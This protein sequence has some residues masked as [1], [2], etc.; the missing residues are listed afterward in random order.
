[1]KMLYA[2]ALLA[3]AAFS[4]AENLPLTAEGAAVAKTYLSRGGQEL[5]T[6][7]PRGKG[8]PEDWPK[9]KG[10]VPQGIP[11]IC[12]LPLACGDPEDWCK[13]QDWYKEAAEE[14]RQKMAQQ[15]AMA[16]QMEK[17]NAEQIH[18][19]QAVAGAQAAADAAKN[20]YWWAQGPMT[21]GIDAGAQAVAGA[22]AAV[23]AAK[24]AYWMAFAEEKATLAEDARKKMAQQKAMEQ[25]E[26]WAE[27][28]RQ[29]MAQQKAMA[30]QTEKAN[31]EQIQ[32]MADETEKMVYLSGMVAYSYIQKAEGALLNQGY[33][34]PHGQNEM[35]EQ[36]KR[37]AGHFLQYDIGHEPGKFTANIWLYDNPAMLIKIESFL[38]KTTT[39]INMREKAMAEQEATCAEATKETAE[40][41]AM[42]DQFR[43]EMAERKATWAEEARQ[44]MAE[45]NKEIIDSLDDSDSYTNAGGPGPNAWAPV[46]P[47]ANA[48][49]VVAPSAPVVGSEPGIVF[50]ERRPV[51]GGS[52]IAEPSAKAAST[53]GAGSLIVGTLGVALVAALT[54]P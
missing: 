52:I 2:L 21:V 3:L 5:F 25:M 37:M 18:G 15:K 6:Y 43:K 20:A 14:A 23:D 49:A 4:H 48:W 17:A 42:A 39:W 44:K 28:A 46:A 40:Q 24:K 11:R 45:Q 38:A 36:W 19:A 16:E 53:H 27:E 51:V 29:K 35:A 54:L 50:R 31:A 10:K 8:D 22:Q 32:G 13:E 47:V 30:E 41:R 1:M 12:T 9:G 26:T 33:W 34:F 7:A